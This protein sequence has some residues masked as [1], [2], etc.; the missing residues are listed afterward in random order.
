MENTAGKLSG[1]GQE[2]SP[3]RKWAGLTVLKSS[4]VVM[5]VLEDD[6]E[7]VIYSCGVWEDLLGLVLEGIS[8]V[9]S[10]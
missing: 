6:F 1:C 5:R 8:V 10:A 4:K 2:K 3:V 9:I 7:A